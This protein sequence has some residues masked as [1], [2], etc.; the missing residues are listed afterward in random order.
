M[1]AKQSVLLPVLFNLMFYLLICF[2]CFY[3]IV[4]LF[5]LLLP[6][7]LTCRLDSS[8]HLFVTGASLRKR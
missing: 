5:L 7:M 8:I 3:F 4:L 6:R 2:I 1:T